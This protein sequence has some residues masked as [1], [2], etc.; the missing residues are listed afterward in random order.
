MNPCVSRARRQHK[1]EADVPTAAE[2][3]DFGHLRRFTLGDKHLEAEIL[4][5]FLAQV[6]ITIA[7][8]K[9]AETD[10]AWYVAAHTLKG[11]ARAVGAQR[12]AL[13]ATQAE[14]LGGVSDPDACRMMVCML[15]EAAEEAQAFVGSLKYKARCGT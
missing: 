13:L 2:P 11:S 5:L 3:V 4:G 15:E 10:G 1:S 12:L 8:L 7:T 9:R 14:R 6:P